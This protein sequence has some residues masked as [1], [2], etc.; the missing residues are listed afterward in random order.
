MPF[1]CRY[2]KYFCVE[3][4]ASISQQIIDLLNVQ[5]AWD[6][7][8]NY[9]LQEEVIV[10]SECKAIEAKLDLPSPLST[11]ERAYQWLLETS[12]DSGDKLWDAVLLWINDKEIID[13]LP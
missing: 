3:T 2:S 13:L 8:L 6:L 10:Y 9:L 12:S 11:G 4:L 5:W 7:L 1:I